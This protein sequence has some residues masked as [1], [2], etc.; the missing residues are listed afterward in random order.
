MNALKLV[1]WVMLVGFAAYFSHNSSSH[2]NSAMTLL[3]HNRFSFFFLFISKNR[4]LFASRLFLILYSFWSC[5]PRFLSIDS[6]IAFSGSFVRPW[7]GNSVFLVLYT[8]IDVNMKH[9]QA[10]FF[11][12]LCF[13]SL[14]K[15]QFQS[16][17]YQ[18]FKLFEWA[19]CGKALFESW[20]FG[21][22]VGG[23]ENDRK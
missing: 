20:I 16:G 13:S 23:N 5:F 21:S 4:C 14:Y 8:T 17:G 15:F 1:N 2:C 6:F 7:A 18:Y 12:F 9:K 3:V 19:W 22:F 11:F 10:S